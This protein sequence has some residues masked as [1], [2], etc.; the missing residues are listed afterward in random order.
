MLMS[1]F[2]ITSCCELWVAF[3]FCAVE[4]PSLKR[5]CECSSTP[6]RDLKTK[7]LVPTIDISNW[8]YACHLNELWLKLECLIRRTEEQYQ[9]FRPHVPQANF[10]V[11]QCK[12]FE[13]KRSEA[14]LKSTFLVFPKTLRSIARARKMPPTRSVDQLRC[15][16]ADGARSDSP[17][18]VKQEPISRYWL[19]RQM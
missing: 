1:E 2:K 9:V 4:V 15:L 14:N 17:N 19:V 12:L 5:R 3:C 7:F 16:R 10:D 6:G 13:A 8:R 11:R 18:R